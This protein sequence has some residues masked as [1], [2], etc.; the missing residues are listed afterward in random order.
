[1]S[2][3]TLSDWSKILLPVAILCGSIY[4]GAHIYSIPTSVETI[5]VNEVFVDDASV[6]AYDAGVGDAGADADAGSVNVRPTAEQL[7]DE[8]MIWDLRDLENQATNTED[9]QL[10]QSA[11]E[12]KKQRNK[13]YELSN[14][15]EKN[16]KK[17]IK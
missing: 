8:Y 9:K 3:L 14:D 12:I 7:A 17:A 11:I 2:K 15:F 13:K 6:A 10:I 5:T 1:M 16:L 4:L